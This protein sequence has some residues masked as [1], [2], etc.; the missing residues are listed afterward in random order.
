MVGGEYS[1]GLSILIQPKLTHNHQT[2][3]AITLGLCGGLSTYTSDGQ[4]GSWMTQSACWGFSFMIGIY[5][6]GGISGGH[7]N[8]AITISMSL[9]RGFPARRC[10]IYILAQLI[11]AI[12]AGGFAYAIYH[13]A[14]VNLSVE[15]NL[16]QSET[17]AS[18]AF[19]TL[20]KQ[21]VSPATAF[22]NEF[23]GT[24]ILVGTIMAL[25]DDTNAPP[26]A[27]MQAFI[28]GILITVLVLALG[29]N[30]GGYVPPLS[31]TP[32]APTT[33]NYQEHSTAP[34]TSA[35]GSSP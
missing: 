29:Y 19:L 12:T 16:P 1:L 18:Q 28:I 7:L 32:E 5:I 4:A 6:V 33:N 30:T 35:P 34:A 13:D 3:I 24:A 23:L 2:T 31:P 10:V 27:G 17:T 14:I 25:G 21:F 20:P 26:G 11:G 8:P 15:T 9:W 22:F